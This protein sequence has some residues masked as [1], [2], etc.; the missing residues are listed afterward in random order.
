[1][2]DNQTRKKDFSQKF[3]IKKILQILSPTKIMIGDKKMSYTQDQ[4]E[5][6]EKY[7]NID[8]E[9]LMKEA[10]TRRMEE[11]LKKNNIVVPKIT[12]KKNRN[13]YYCNIPC[14]Y[15]EDKE[16]HQITGA[17]E[18]ECLDKY[19]KTVY[20]F[21]RKKEEPPRTFARTYK[22]W[23]DSK[24][25]GIRETTYERYLRM[26]YVYI[27][28]SEFGAMKLSDIR[29]PE[30]ETFIQSLYKKGICKESLNQVK[31]TLS[32]TM[33]YAI[34]HEYEGSRGNFFRSIHI[35][36]NLCSTQYKHRTDA[37]SDD[38]IIALGENSLKYWNKEKKYRYSAVFM[39][40]IYTG[41]RIGEMLALE[42][43]D[44]DFQ[45]KTMKISKTVIRY[46]DYETKKKILKI[47][48]PKTASSNRTIMLTDE[49]MFWL[50]E[51]KKRNMQSGCNQTGR[52]VETSGGLIVKPD[53][54]N[55]AIK[56]M[57]NRIGIEYRSS[58]TCRRT[59][60]TVLMENGIPTP[61]VSADLGHKNLSTTQNSYYKRRRNM[62]KQLE[63]KNQIFLS[64]AVHT[65]KQA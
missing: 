13:L 35:N 4:I 62:E 11:T 65:L 54:V 8:I 51:I 7:G 64:T 21:L 12:K 16:R 1:M 34:A 57:C 9:G 10:E 41:C 2:N 27:K 52:V 44:I 33:E 53:K 32:Q 28:D 60:A 26:Y 24:R 63:E 15:S 25:A 14:H 46:T 31:S 48:A 61:E 23:L 59:Y 17:T 39:A 6:L 19:K 45:K 40:M 47:G 37:W 38:E 30:C 5:M 3:A 42:W 20:A 49:A 55:N 22:E 36:E 29:L 56:R 50:R 18:E 43:K 58:H